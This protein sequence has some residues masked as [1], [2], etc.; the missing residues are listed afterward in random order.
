MIRIATWSS[1]F[2][3]LCERTCKTLPV[4]YFLHGHG[5]GVETYVGLSRLQEAADKAVADGVREMILVLPDAHT[6]YNADM[7]SNSLTTG[8]REG[9]ISQ[10]LVGYIDSHY[11]TVANRDSRRPFRTFHGWVRNDARGYEDL[12]KCLCTLFHER[13]LSHEQSS[14]AARCRAART[15]RCCADIRCRSAPDQCR[16]SRRP[17]RARRRDRECA[18]CAGRRM[19]AEPDESSAVFSIFRPRTVRCS[20]SS[21]RSGWPTAARDGGSVC[22]EPEAISRYC[23]RRRRQGSARRLEPRSRQGATRLGIAHTFEQF[24][25]DHTNRA[26]VR[27]LNYLL[28]FFEAA[29]VKIQMLTAL[30]VLLSA[31]GATPLPD[32]R[33]PV[34][35]TAES[36]PFMAA[37]KSTPALDL[38]KIGYVEEEFVVS[39]T[40]NVYDWA[41]DGSVNVKTPSAP[42]TTCIV[43]RRPVSNSAER[44]LSS[45]C[46]R[47]GSSIGR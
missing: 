32:V 3:K 1:I 18:L 37:H 33:G 6:I 44:S 22:A 15:W 4:V 9:F 42:Y 46:I 19:G 29:E 8:H 45:F 28:P 26:A 43:V 12:P 31:V 40:S 21:R 20:A 13:V 39:G 7:Y 17:W 36:Y 14:P 2:P 23:Y 38:S 16:T 47:R 5:V 35:V 27:F 24:E 41:A 30:A 34:P 25:G 11:R 10:D